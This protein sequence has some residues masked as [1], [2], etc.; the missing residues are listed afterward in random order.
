MAGI[1][2]EYAVIA[3]VIRYVGEC[4]YAIGILKREHVSEDGSKREENRRNR[5]EELD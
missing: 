1:F 4:H 5:D 2:F 3:G